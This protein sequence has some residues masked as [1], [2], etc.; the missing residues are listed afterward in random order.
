[1]KDELFLRVDKNSKGVEGRLYRAVRLIALYQ[2]SVDNYGWTRA[3]KARYRK[4]H[5][6][7]FKLFW[8]IVCN[9]FPGYK[10][11]EFE[12]MGSRKVI[13]LQMNRDIRFLIVLRKE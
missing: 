3:Y 10:K 12:T 9:H 13:D 11:A 4:A 1:M 6:S 8:K 5:A 2:Y 7:M